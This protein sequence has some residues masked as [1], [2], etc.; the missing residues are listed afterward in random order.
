MKSGW[1]LAYS[2][3][4]WWCQQQKWATEEKEGV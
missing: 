4:E 1:G 2:M 3:G